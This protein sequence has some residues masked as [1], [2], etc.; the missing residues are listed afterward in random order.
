MECM[1]GPTSIPVKSLFRQASQLDNGGEQ[2]RLYFRPGSDGK[3]PP[4][5]A[6]GKEWLEFDLPGRNGLQAFL[7]REEGGRYLV[8]K[9][10]HFM[11]MSGK[12]ICVEQRA[13]FGPFDQGTT[14]IQHKVETASTGECAVGEALQNTNYGVVLNTLCANR[15]GLSSIYRRM[16]R[17]APAQ[18]GEITLWL[19]ISEYGEVNDAKL[20]QSTMNSPEFEFRVLRA[21]SNFDFGRLNAGGWTG[22]QTLRF[23]Q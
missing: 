21:V 14:E 20:I 22:E 15:G 7:K 8:G 17:R 5:L 16:S 1:I 3:T 9:T 19:S 12:V 23:P 11:E 18:Q 6:L 13:R 10:I 4:P 2:V